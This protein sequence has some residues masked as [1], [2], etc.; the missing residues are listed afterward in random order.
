MTWSRVVK[1]R[2]YPKLQAVPIL[3]PVLT[4]L[5]RVVLMGRRLKAFDTL[6]DQVQHVS[7]TL[8][9]LVREQEAR[10]ADGRDA[11]S[12]GRTIRVMAATLEAFE[13]RLAR[14][15]ARGGEGGRRSAVP[16]P[17]PAA[18][19]PSASM[20]SA[21]MPSG[22]M[23]S[24]PSQGG[25]L[26][27]QER[28]K[29]VWADGPERPAVSVVVNTFNRASTLPATLA[30]LRQLRYPVFEVIVVNGPS[31]D[32]TEDVLRAHEGLIT[33]LSCPEANLS[34]SRNI[35]I[36]AARGDIVAFIDDDA[37]PEPDWLD[38]IVAPFA[39][40]RV[41]GAGGFTRD[42]SGVS[43]QCKAVIADRFG[44]SQAFESLEA[45]GLDRQA[46]SEAGHD[47]FI[48]TTGTN[49]AF[50]RDALLS[51]GGFDEAYA[52]FLDETDVNLRMTD[53]GWTTALVPEAE[54]HHK[55]APSHLR[56]ERRVPKSMTI[57]A[58]SKAYFV[59][60]HAGARY[61]IARAAD[62]MADYLK[63][64]RGFKRSSVTIGDLDP[65][66]FSRL[67]AETEQGVEEGIKR[68]MSQRAP[69]LLGEEL[70]AAHGN[71][72]F[73]PVPVL[74]P[75]ERRL[76]IVFLSQSWG[77]DTDS[78]IAVWTRHAA[79]GL[80]ARGHEVSV[81]TKS[82]HGQHTVDFENGVW[83]HRVVADPKAERRF[84]PLPHLPEDVAAHCIA[85]Y[86]E[87][88]RIALRRGLHV[89]SGPLWDVEPMAFLG[90]GTVPFVVSLHTSAA[91]A[92]PSKPDW[93]SRPDYCRDHVQPVIEA[94]TMLLREAPALLANSQA[95]LRDLHNAH[96]V[97]LGDGR[98]TVIAHGLAD[99]PDT[100]VNR[101][102]DG[103]VRLLFVGRLEMR[104]GAD[105]LFGALPQIMGVLT[106]LDVTIVGE[107]PGAEGGD[108][109][110]AAFCEAHR[111][112]AWFDRVHYE[113]AIDRTL[114]ES[115]YGQA[116]IVAVPSRYESFGL[117]VIEAL[118]AGAVPVASSVGGMAEILC[119]GENGL[120][121]P[122]ANRTALAE[123]IRRLVED[124][125]LRRRLSAA[126]RRH[127]EEQYT[128]DV[129]VGALERYY[130]RIGGVSL[131]VAP[132]FPTARL[133]SA[134]PS[135]ASSSLARS[136]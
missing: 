127:Y 129:M 26:D 54:V 112:A 20:S 107:E 101:A 7:T 91:L 78:G 76:R 110:W 17:P 42:N 113:G 33:S 108:G 106:T 65:D 98:A 22:P 84:P 94:E 89:I 4:A 2:I 32:D 82:P 19:S 53:A 58:R 24:A 102:A 104:K 15:E 8:D 5:V 100:R 95:L 125:D 49:A 73:K 11:E 75:T 16:A 118:R 124:A 70:L 41:G 128:A 37:V 60:R 87:V 115:F 35:G 29:A 79:E 92:M 18:S 50:R 46:G 133:P 14:L 132:P 71:R 3:G 135:S 123:A 117:V 28:L 38:R 64:E 74:R 103:M 126:G 81:V 122:P 88:M 9:A 116:D 93:T 10:N 97:D 105:V 63:R 130:A 40:P 134:A 36:A 109:L 30:G 72:S 57:P 47:R 66:G 68:A 34:M 99:V 52:Y 136:A 111:D 44:D 13:Q 80:G 27:L 12:F 1:K 55:Y 6:K 56:D 48:S 59:Y 114:L 120:L 23:L 96:G 62:Y 131:G 83:V 51:V 43:F 121:V 86:D 67:T 25:A 21:S 90:A 85:A 31:T 61:G 69:A 39:D 45:S 77:P 119:H